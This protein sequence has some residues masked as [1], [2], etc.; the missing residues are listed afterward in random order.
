LNFFSTRPTERRFNPTFGTRLYNYLF[1]QNVSEF[2]DI[3][4]TVIKEDVE[5]W[6][7]NVFVNQVFLD[8][9]P[10]QKTKDNDNYIIRIRVQFNYNNQSSSFSFDVTN[11]T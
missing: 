1:E 8:Y 4:K 3:L 9:P 5:T 7:P 11:N 6:F 10:G 2:E